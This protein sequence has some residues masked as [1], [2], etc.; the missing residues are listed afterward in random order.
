MSSRVRLEL[1]S[2]KEAEHE[3]IGP[4]NSRILLSFLSKKYSSNV[5]EVNFSDSEAAVDFCYELIE[6]CRTF[7]FPT[8]SDDIGVHDTMMNLAAITSIY[9]NLQRIKPNNK[10]YT[11][12]SL[13]WG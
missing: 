12:Y 4:Y 1:V 3:V 13:R 6:L 10:R 5:G 8:E 11:G 2:A 7:T 9:V